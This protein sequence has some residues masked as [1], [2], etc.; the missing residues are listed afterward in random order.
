MKR[1]VSILLVLSMLLPTFAF[2]EMF[3]SAPVVEQEQAPVID[4]VEL[5]ETDDLMV[6]PQG[7]VGAPAAYDRDL[8]LLQPSDLVGTTLN[9]TSIQLTWSPVAFATQY[10]VY[11][12]L[13]NESE[14]IKLDS[15]PQT[16]LYYVDAAVPT[17]TVCYYRVQALNVSYDGDTR[18]DTYS[19]QSNTLPFITLAAPTLSDPRGLDADTIR[20]SWGSVNGATTYEVEYATSKGGAFTLVR[21]D[22]TGALCNIDGVQATKGYYFRVRAVRTF[23]SGEKFYS[24]Y[25]DVKVG[26][27]MDRPEL[28]VSMDGN[29]AVLSW[30]ACQGAN[31]YVIYRKIGGGSYQKLAVTGNVTSYVDAGRVAGE[32]CY[33]FVYAMYPIGDSNCFSLSSA[34]RYF[35]VVGGVEVCAVQNTG[36]HEQTINWVSHA[37]GANKYYV[38]AATSLNGL[39]EKI[40]ECYDTKFVAADLVPGLTYFYKVRPVREFSNGD[41][42]MGPWSNIMSMPESGTLHVGGLSGYNM[43]HGA[44]ISG[45]YVGDVFNWSVN[46]SG[47]SGA[48]DF[49]WSLVSID[50]AGSMLLN[51][52]S[53]NYVPLPEDKDTLTQ[54]YGMVLTEQ[55]VNA[56]TN[57][58][59]A[60]QVEVRDSLGAVGAIYACGDTWAE[61]NF[62]ANAPVSKT[63]NITMRP[64][65]VYTI[66]HGIFTQAG[67]YAIIGVS[68]PTGAV[69]IDGNK[70]TAVSNGFA[71]LLITPARFRNDVLIVYN[72]TVGYATLAINRI[73]P[74]KL[75]AHNYEMLEWDVD[76]TGGRPNYNVELKVYQG[77]TV[78]ANNVSTKTINGLVSAN[79]QPTTP[80]Q[81]YLEAVISSADGQ[82][83]T[84]RSAVTTVTAYNPITI[85]PSVTSTTIG[86]N[87]TWATAYSG[88]SVVYRRDYT[89]FRD[90]TVIA[91]TSGRNELA[92]N[93]TPTQAGSYVLQVK[94]Y[95]ANGNVITATS[96]TVT[97]GAAGTVVT[98][99]QGRVTADKVALRKG[100]G[101]EHAVITRLNR[102]KIVNIIKLVGDWYYV[103]YNGTYGYMHSDYVNPVVK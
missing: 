59:Y 67:D 46:V 16:Q 56:I 33:Y 24:A 92:F 102:G 19:P 99:T 4:E 68:N 54:S 5:P 60:M 85:I 95:E 69:V 57:Q 88:D 86:T 22:L 3:G 101:T 41:V 58:K 50:G 87:I 26:T 97:V 20:L 82:R 45:G 25:S 47:G 12:K 84:M 37:P 72:F 76:F 2:G 52:F 80:G 103:N 48:Y 89:L 9:A 64:G 61:L 6:V 28:S 53:G 96:Q 77:N 44:A 35:T 18:V 34:T 15:V 27:P 74:S 39:Y 98:G 66:N 42:T 65:D 8:V 29:N 14:Y 32:V 49:K 13:G 90:G 11:R 71:T 75:T 51:D 78:V 79:Y 23:S 83:A 7:N 10:D 93:Y 30:S 31:G 1:L 81:Y 100:P 36:E 91:S 43:T 62:V 21:K 94:V 73:T 55:M 63:E 40:G 70:I 17:G 38:Y